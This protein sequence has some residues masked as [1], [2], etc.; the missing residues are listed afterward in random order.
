MVRRRRLNIAT[1]LGADPSL[2]AQTDGSIPT[3]YPLPKLT[4]TAGEL[5]LLDSDT[6]VPVI[7]GL[8]RSTLPDGQTIQDAELLAA[9][10]FTEAAKSIGPSKVQA[11]YLI[12]IASSLWTFHAI[13]TCPEKTHVAWLTTPKHAQVYVSLQAQIQAQTA[14]S[15]ASAAPDYA[16]LATLL[17]TGLKR[18][19]QAPTLSKTS[20]GTTQPPPADWHADVELSTL[21][22][23][24]EAVKGNRAVTQAYLETV[25][26]FSDTSLQAALASSQSHA[27][28][29]RQTLA[30]SSQGASGLKVNLTAAV[31]PIK[32]AAELR[33]AINYLGKAF[34]PLS[35]QLSIA[36][37]IDFSEVLERVIKT[38]NL[39]TAVVYGN[40]VLLNMMNYLRTKLQA[41]HARRGN[42]E[43]PES[44]LYSEITFA[45]D[46]SLLSTAKTDAVSFRLPRD[47]RERDG[48]SDRDRD[49]KPRER[50]ANQAQARDLTRSQEQTGTVKTESHAPHVLERQTK[51]P[52]TRSATP[53]LNAANVSCSTQQQADAP[54]CTR[55]MTRAHKQAHRNLASNSKAAKRKRRSASREQSVH[56]TDQEELDE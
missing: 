25:R 19:L 29:R 49:R 35:T 27:N 22:S 48:D 24:S 42:S 8:I 10:G 30:M 34:Q 21:P 11:S 23:W 50:H 36:L 28:D 12:M 37:R 1:L 7:M 6:T 46:D 54:S 5:D 31:A 17:D 51:I 43:A 18:R 40:M 55:R 33:E 9:L 14:V 13:A 16:S 26:T 20:K 39:I 15:S 4:T 52:A 41:W 47:R 2:S 38:Y 3:G 32:S 56:D 45:L 44:Y 53:T